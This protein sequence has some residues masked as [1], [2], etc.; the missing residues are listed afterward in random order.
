MIKIST[1]AKNAI[2]TRYT[3]ASLALIIK[4]IVIAAIRFIGALKQI[5]RII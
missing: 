5:R 1:T 2:A 3:I 4:V